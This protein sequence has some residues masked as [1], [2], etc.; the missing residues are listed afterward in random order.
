MKKIIFSL[1]ACI[2][3]SQ[4]QASIFQSAVNSIID[5]VDPTINISMSVVDLNTGEQLF[6]RNADRTLIPAS[7]MKLFSEAAALLALGPDYRFRRQLSTDATRLENGT[8]HGS[9]YLT[10]PGDPSFTSHHLED[11]LSTL[12]RWGI[13][14]ITG[15]VVMVN[16]NASVDPYPP[17]R[18]PQ[19]KTHSYGAPITPIIIDENRLTMIVNPGQ[20]PNDDAIIEVSAPV[21]VIS[22]RNTVKTASK[23]SLSAISYKLDSD[24]HL[25]ASGA[26]GSE[27]WAFEKHIAIL[28]PLKYAQ[29]LIKYQLGE[30]N[31]TLN[32]SVIQGSLPSSTLVLASQASKPLNHLMADTLK[33]SDNVF[34]DSLF[35]HTAS[36]L[37]GSS[38]NWT[39]ADHVAKQ[40]LQQQTGIN[41][42]KAVLVDGSG[43]SKQ[44]RVSAKQTVDLLSY[45]YTHFPIAYEFI[46]ALPI[47]GRDGTL[48]HRFNTHAQQGMVRAKTGTMTGIISLSGY[49]SAANGHTLAFAMYINR[50]SKTAPN[51]AGRYHWLIDQL[52]NYFLK[53]RP[54][55]IANIP[56]QN[57][58]IDVAF[59]QHPSVALTKRTEKAEWRGLEMALRK[60][61]RGKMVAVLYKKNELVLKDDNANINTVLNALASVNK[62]YS[63]S[64]ALESPREPQ[65]SHASLKILWIKPQNPTL[66]SRTWIIRNNPRQSS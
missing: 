38:I 37:N 57:S 29:D 30:Q 34:A 60:A 15:N 41:L 42:A 45:I 64:V 2:I 28:N 21:S 56:L 32:G 1:F 65:T 9:V 11:L 20:K 47:A 51:V 13:K 25:T 54:V 26:I 48:Q 63:F 16:K 53:Q 24:N 55:G 4:S 3:Y 35:I 46:A 40:F 10:L 27:T 43:L 44:D 59:Q 66:T 61:L 17:G 12:S 18:D 31:I 6:S 8:L 52:C 7:N 33:P 19:D 5:K 14:R 22:I 49:L 62:K 36:M 23:P 58:H 39:Q 50:H